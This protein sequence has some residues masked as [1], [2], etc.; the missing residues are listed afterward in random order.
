[1]TAQ[2]T[3]PPGPHAAPGCIS[4]LVITTGRRLGHASGHVARDGHHSP[5]GS[6]HADR[7]AV[8]TRDIGTAPASGATRDDIINEA[9]QPMA[10]FE[11]TA[12]VAV[13][14]ARLHL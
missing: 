1:M 4:R 13:R 11:R 14:A 9:A 2:H 7:A 3:D 6:D 10:V 12:L 5:T 8:I